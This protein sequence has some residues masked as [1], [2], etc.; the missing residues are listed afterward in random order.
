LNESI[1]GFLIDECLSAKLADLARE[2][3]YHALATTRM[4][5]LRKRDDYRV[6]RFALDRN[7]V[8]VTNDMYDLANV[9]A[10]FEVHP[11]IVFIT[12]GHT[13]LRNLPYQRKMFGAVLDELEDADPMS[14]AVLVTAK[15]GKERAVKITLK[16]YPYPDRAQ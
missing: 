11:G 10:G 13:K 5:R 9:Y 7:L 16:R 3:G 8:L 2:R 1:A 14:E 4:L 15:L 12:A 6:A